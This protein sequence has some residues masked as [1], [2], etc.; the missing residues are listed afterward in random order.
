VTGTSYGI[1]APLVVGAT[2]VVDEA[3]FDV[4]RWYGILE[5]EKVQVWYTAPTAIRMLMKRR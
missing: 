2:M 4:P 5:E 1:I 3:E